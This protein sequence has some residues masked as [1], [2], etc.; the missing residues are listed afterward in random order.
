MDGRSILWSLRYLCLLLLVHCIRVACES[1][2]YAQPDSYAKYPRWRTAQD[3][4]A[5]FSFLTSQADALLFYLDSDNDSG[6]Y[7]V[8]WLEGGRLKARTKVGTGAGSVLGT[9]FGEH[10]N[11]LNLHT[12]L[13]RHYDK[14]FTFHLDS[15]DLVGN[16]T[17][18]QSHLQ[19]QTR[20]YV[21]IGGLP[22]SHV[23]DY[24][25]A[26]RIEP[27][28]GCVKRVS[29][30]DDSIERLQMEPRDP[31]TK[32]Q[33][34][35]GCVDRCATTDA[36]CGDGGGTCVRSWAVPGGYFC[37]CSAATNVGQSCNTGE[38]IVFLFT[39]LG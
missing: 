28:A 20:S 29:F 35:D 4:L 38:Q 30:A 6:N 25:A 37:D 23:P 15:M 21:Y 32:H 3:G 27:L 2:T 36:N 5:E 14:Q 22:S 12:L 8:I 26:A 33:L 39:S 11:D 34:A 16:L 24:E 1:Y 19:F 31:V 18:D 7:L 10:L 13:I 17:Y 9:T